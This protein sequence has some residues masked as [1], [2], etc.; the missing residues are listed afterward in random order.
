MKPYK[1]LF[2]YEDSLYV[3]EKEKTIFYE[4]EAWQSSSIKFVEAV[5]N[6]DILG[7]ILFT[8]FFTCMKECKNKTYRND[9]FLFYDINKAFAKEGYKVSFV[10][11]VVPD[12]KDGIVKMSSDMTDNSI[13]ISCDNIFTEK[14][15]LGDKELLTTFKTLIKHELVHIGQYLRMKAASLSSIVTRL[16]DKKKEFYKKLDKKDFSV[17]E[18]EE[19]LYYKYFSNTKELMAYAKTA[20]LELQLSGLSKEEILHGIKTMFYEYEKT[21]YPISKIIN[22]YHRYFRKDILKDMEYLK[23][24]Y[25]YLYEYYMNYGKELLSMTK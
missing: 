14:F 17:D 15:L 16:L 12:S 22:N 21:N 23:R 2:E 10:Y 3:S 19:L 20:L 18:K 6:T 8:I 9:L 13:T 5:I 24:F 1:R 25:K 4:N 11:E 7:D